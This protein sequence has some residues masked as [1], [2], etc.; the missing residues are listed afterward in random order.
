M[1]VSAARF[2]GRDSSSS[3]GSGRQAGRQEEPLAE[4][5]GQTRGGRGG[6]G[7]SGEGVLAQS[8]GRTGQTDECKPHM[9]VCVCAP[10]LL[11]LVSSV[12]AGMDAGWR[13]ALPAAEGGKGGEGRPVG[14]R[15][16]RERT[17]SHPSRLYVSSSPSSP[18]SFDLMA[19]AVLLLLLSG[20]RRISCWPLSCSPLSSPFPS[21]S[22]LGS[23]RAQ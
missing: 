20:L 10:S 8:G 11:L 9:R 12:L 18:R 19:A 17:G 2:E 7:K 3:S 22:K 16:G 5:R 14:V 13:A 23:A 15:G 1:E 21:P 6:G 4:R